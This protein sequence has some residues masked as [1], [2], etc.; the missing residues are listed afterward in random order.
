MYVVGYFVGYRLALG[1]IRRG[2]SMLTAK[3]LD[4]L[5]SY[6]V[7]GPSRSLPQTE[8]LDSVRCCCL[9]APYGV[10]PRGLY[11]ASVVATISSSKAAPA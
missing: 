2:I 6:S 7:V 5:I 10:M 3:D 1:R 8:D 4:T 9:R 11:T